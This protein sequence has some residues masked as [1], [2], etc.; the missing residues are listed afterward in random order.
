MFQKVHV[1]E[2]FKKKIYSL[3]RVRLGSIYFVK[4]EFFLLKVL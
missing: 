1:L 2:N 3:L 4:I